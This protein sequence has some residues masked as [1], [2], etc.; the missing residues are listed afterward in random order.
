MNSSVNK[1]A[2][3]VIESSARALDRMFTYEIPEEFQSGL[4]VGCVVEVP[5]GSRFLNGVVVDV[6]TE[7]SEQDKQYSLRPISQVLEA[8]PFWG[9]E[10]MKLVQIMRQFYAGSWYDSF[11]TVVPTPVMKRLRS[12]WAKKRVLSKKR[13]KSEIKDISD[14]P[15][16]PLTSEQDKAVEMI[17]RSADDGKPVLLYGVTGSGKTE[18]YL[19]ALHR[20][21]K[22][23]RQG[24]VLVPELSLTPQAIERYCGRLGDKVGVLHSALGDAE[25]RD[26]WWAMRRGEL[27]VALGTR[28]A[29]F[30]PF[31]N[32]GFICV[33]EEHESS[34]KQENQPRYHAR[35]VAFMRAKQHKAALVLGSATPSI[36]SYY[37]AQKGV[38]R[39]A[40]LNSRPGG[41]KLPPIRLIDMRLEKKNG[42]LISQALKEALKL[43]LSRGEQ[44]VLLL[45]RRGFAGS[46]QC[47]ACG[48]VPHCPNCSISL[49]WHRQSK[50]LICHYC[51]YRQEVSGF[52][53]KCKDIKFKMGVP[54]AERLA[55]EIAELF[56]GVGISRLDRDTVSRKG[57]H[58][59][60]LE[61]FSS[62]KTQI[63]LGT[64][65][66]AKGLDYP[67]V[68][69]VGILR[70]DAE[71]S[72]PD[73]RAGEHTFQLLS[74]AAGRAGRGDLGGEV[75]LQVWDAENPVIDAV[76]N[77][78]YQSMYESEIKI[79]R[80]LLYPPFRRL[81]RFIISG[82]D[83]LQVQTAAA[84]AADILRSAFAA[85]EVVGPA[86]CP[87]E[88]LQGLYRRHLLVKAKPE[89]SLR[90]LVSFCT[91][92]AA[93]VG[94]KNNG[95]RLSVDPD[96][97][98]LI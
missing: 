32:I 25:R 94:E 68:T 17:C 91:K 2:R 97:Q 50:K 63:L 64:K 39:L 9:G 23:G 67:R 65:M 58:Q 81:I 57:S 20:I 87:I 19:Q 49:A 35:Q 53:P 28:S 18:V 90:Q 82:E 6:Y 29:I 47:N 60:I 72:Q 54:G 88:R 59:A 69:L 42:G 37:L 84:Q 93:E 96:P 70:A 71:L 10:L 12:M 21:L 51:D 3:V 74:Q 27:S 78:D 56:P 45:N 13:L 41:R 36:E 7:L 55:A 30:A 52:C 44:S 76:V 66:I 73:F 11:Q 14:Y 15:L 95:T 92:V 5:L 34:Y 62:G 98:S 43:R 85:D 86:P 80:Q 1:Y 31:E 22:Q 8:A 89:Y 4:A 61:E 38:Y 75:F 40:K 16:L 79:R 24:I 46:L 83:D 77:Y 48:Y 26:Y 33:D